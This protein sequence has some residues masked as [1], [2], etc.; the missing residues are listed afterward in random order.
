M[1]Q[2]AFVQIV[3]LKKTLLLLFS[4]F[5]VL[6]VSV[7]ITTEIINSQPDSV[8]QSIAEKFN[9]I[10]NQL[11]FN[12]LTNSLKELTEDYTKLFDG[13][14]NIIITDNKGN[15]LF[16]VNSGY[17]SEKDK[18]F[19]LIDPWDANGYDSNIAY[20]ID[21]KNTI[22]YSAQLDIALNTSSLKEQ[23]SLDPISKELYSDTQ[24]AF[25]TFGN[26]QVTNGDGT[27]YTVS[28]E[29]N[30]VLNYEYIA[31]KG[32]NL[33]SVYDS[34]HQ[35]NNYYL[36]A[37]SIRYSRHWLII[38]ALAV[39]FLFWVLLPAWV[40][41]DARRRRLKASFWTLMTFFLSIPGLGIYLIFRPGYF[42]CGV[43]KKVLD[44]GWILCPYCGEKV[45]T[46]IQV[47]SE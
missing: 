1:L 13:F 26:R 34:E 43:C 8:Q 28:P 14:S 37:N 6:A 45:H 27:T 39:L 4:L 11:E 30:M 21:S 33:Y 36:V 10:K 29:T 44:N 41:N 22:K 42:R 16:K 3:N 35:Y 12:G 25:D 9:Q 19:V 5:I 2:F 7:L 24:D 40:F 17:I 38:A 23:S 31:S 15:I 46:D 20:L 32:L 47:K 18:F